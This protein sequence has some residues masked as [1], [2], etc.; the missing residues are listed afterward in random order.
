MIQSMTGY[1]ETKIDSKIFSVRISIKSLNHR[2]FDWSCRGSQIS[3]V[4][5]RLRVICQKE[6]SRGRI[7]VFVDLNFLES[8]RWDLRIN[9]D[10]L[11]KILVS[12]GKISSKMETKA[13]FSLDNMF[14]IPHIASIKRQN[15]TPGETS[16]LEKCFTKTLAELRKMRL[17]EGKQLVSE[18]RSHM[19]VIKL[20][21]KRIERLEKKHPLLIRKKLQERIKDLN[22]SSLISEGKMMEETA[23]IAQRYDL[24]EEIERLNSH[25]IFFQELLSSKT[26]EPV[27]KKLDFLAQELFREVNTINSKAQDIKIIRESLTIKGEVESIR[28]QVQN[29]E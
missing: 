18:I 7:E 14:S 29:L 3:E 5:N 22:S 24:R 1:A 15:L 9:E 23:F 6:I 25:I 20:A 19:A 8:T 27:G 2:F 28:Q 12:L 17:R 13:S 10:L 4:E 16:F 11:S 26:G 21:L